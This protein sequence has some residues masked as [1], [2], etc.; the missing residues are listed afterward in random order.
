MPTVTSD[1]L[2]D[3]D[4]ALV[5][6]RLIAAGEERP[7]WLDRVTEALDARRAGDELGRVLSVWGL[8]QADAGR[9]FDV[10]RQAVGKWL[11]GGV[12]AERATA[13]ADLA[14]ATDLLVHHLKRERIAAVVRRPA[15]ALGGRSLLDLVAEGDTRAA[16]DACRT[17]FDVYGAQR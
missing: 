3:Q 16:L 8:S 10:S 7:G 6:Q 17:M 2:A 4:P 12:P 15:P 14:A 9:L 5:A 11:S 13:V 1:P